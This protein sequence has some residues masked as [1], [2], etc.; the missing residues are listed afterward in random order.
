MENDEIKSRLLDLFGPQ[1]EFNKEFSKYAGQ[2]KEGMLKDFIAWCVDCKNGLTNGSTPPKKKY[3][4][5][6]VFFRK[7][8][9]FIFIKNKK[10]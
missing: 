8:K 7:K 4:H 10:K 6:V 2:L 5:L 9:K 3:K 1:L